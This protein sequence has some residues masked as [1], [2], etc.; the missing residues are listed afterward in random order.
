MVNDSVQWGVLAVLLLL[1]LGMYR[2][3][4]LALPPS[5]RAAATGPPVGRRL[6][7]EALSRIRRTVTTGEDLPH[8]LA[9]AFVVENCAGCQRLL[10]D[11]EGYAATQLPPMMVIARKPS[12]QFE[13]AIGQLGVPVLLDTD[14]SVSTACEITATPMVVVINGEGKVKRKEVTHDVQRII[15]EAA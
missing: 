4:S 3:I 14:A 5:A 9:L 8:L 15:V 12:R 6:P 1:V 2:Q 11:L 13:E 7:K 10:S